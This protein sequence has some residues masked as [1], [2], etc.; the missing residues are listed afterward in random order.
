MR[1]NSIQ[2]TQ[3]IS[4]TVMRKNPQFRQL[5][6]VLGLQVLEMFD[7][8]DSNLWNINIIYIAKAR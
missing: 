3:I 5:F 2:G 8:V 7:D 1:L 4:L 6:F